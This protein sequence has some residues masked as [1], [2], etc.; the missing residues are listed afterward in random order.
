MAP[1]CL[2]KRRFLVSYPSKIDYR[3]G[4]HQRSSCFSFSV[5]YDRRGDHIQYGNYA[6]PGGGHQGQRFFFLH[7]DAMAKGI[8]VSEQELKRMKA[9]WRK[10]AYRKDQDHAFSKGPGFRIPTR[11]DAI[12]SRSIYKYRD[13]L[14]KGVESRKL[15]KE[16]ER[17]ITRKWSIPDHSNMPSEE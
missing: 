10:C 12:P 3:L 15:A 11:P 13:P 17:G 9:H 5:E 16:L 6:L 4:P 1:F 2:G 14:R 7:P 8:G